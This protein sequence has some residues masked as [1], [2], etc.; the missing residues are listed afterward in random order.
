[1]QM[2]GGARFDLEE[3]MRD[4]VHKGQRIEPVG[5]DE[6][7]EETR[8]ICVAMRQ[9]FGIAETGKIPEVLLLMLRHPDMYHAQMAFGMMLA[10][11]NLIPAR[12]RELAILRNAWLAGAPF[13]WGEH[14]D[15][16]KRMGLTPEE[17]ERC[18]IG[19]SAEG[20]ND[21]DRAILKGV[22]ELHA[23]FAL[24]DETWDTLARSWSEPQLMEFPVLVGQYIATALQQNT[25]RVRLAPDNPGL[26]HR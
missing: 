14:V 21:H 26:S 16:G 25:L 13:E 22:E 12:E 18:T 5:E 6:L 17:V 8:A 7:T 4:T 11:K 23:N 24:S 9:A 3:R 20:W 15:I 19:S 10:A 2:G 1:M